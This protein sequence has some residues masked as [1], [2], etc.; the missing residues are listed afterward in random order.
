MTKGEAIKLFGS[1]G[2]L[3]RACGIRSQSVSGWPAGKLS[4]RI[5]MRVMMAAAKNGLIP[6]IGKK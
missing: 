3:A 1:V 6:P 5:E 2:A 4:E